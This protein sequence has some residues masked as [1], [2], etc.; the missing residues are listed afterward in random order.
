MSLIQCDEVNARIEEI[1]SGDLVAD[2]TL[3]DHLAGCPE[4]R[5]RL[6]H[7]RAIEAALAGRALPLVPSSF[8]SNVMARIRRERWKAE[9]MLDAGFNA[10]VVAGVLLVL[11]G[12]GGLFWLS[13]L[14]AAAGDF[15]SLAIRATDVFAA[16][17]GDQ[18]QTVLVVVLF[19]TTAFGVWWWTEE[20]L[21]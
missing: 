8:T 21:A 14:P 10:A 3:E 6:A 11:A 9:Q 17:L 4:C 19:F 12:V 15:T 7:A 13:G 16:R 2:R 18:L 20:G 1:A 5:A